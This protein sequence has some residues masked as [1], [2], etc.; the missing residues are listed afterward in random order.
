MELDAYLATLTALFLYPLLAPWKAPFITAW[1]VLWFALW[2]VFFA[3]MEY[4]V[5]VLSSGIVPGSALIGIGILVF[6]TGSLLRLTG[7]GLRHLC[8]SKKLA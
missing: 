6:A 4:D 3:R 7:R 2:A 8:N 1:L 5:G